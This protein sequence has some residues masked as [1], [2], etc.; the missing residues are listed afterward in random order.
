MYVRGYVCVLGTCI[1]VLR[2]RYMCVK[3]HVYVR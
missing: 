3:D 2:V 1:C